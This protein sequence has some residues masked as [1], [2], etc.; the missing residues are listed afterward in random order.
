MVSC[1]QISRLPSLAR[2]EAYAT[3]LPSGE[4][5]GSVFRPASDVSRRSAGK[6]S[7]ARC[8]HDHH[9]AP[10]LIAKIAASPA[11]VVD[12]VRVARGS[13]AIAPAPDIDP[14]SDS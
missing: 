6:E 13:T 8:D 2:S 7:G 4:S 3:S 10:A 9:H 11:G 14:D 5:A 1:T 12:E